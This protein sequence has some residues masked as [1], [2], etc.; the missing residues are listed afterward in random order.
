MIVAV[1][2]VGAK[3]GGAARIA[4]DAVAGLAAHEAV[5]RVVVFASPEELRAFRFASE[6][7]T[8][9]DVIDHP[10]AEAAAGRIMW[11]NNGLG[12]A[13][14][15][16][17]ASVVLSLSSI[18]VVPDVPVVNY[19]QQPLLYDDA[20][21][22]KVSADT[23]ARLMALRPLTWR[24]ARHAAA[25]V[26]QTT[27]MRSVVSEAWNLEPASIVVAT[28][29]PPPWSDL[30]GER[31]ND[32]LW[33]GHPLGYKRWGQAQWIHARFRTF[34]ADSRLLATLEEVSGEGVEA[35][36]HVPAQALRDHY[37]SVGALLV[38]SMSESLGLPL[39]EAMAAG[40]PI[41]APDY[42][43]SR[44]VCDNAALY[45]PPEEPVQAVERLRDARDATVVADLR[46]RMANRVAAIRAEDGWRR[47]A[48][49]VCALG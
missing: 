24:S 39:L 44:A 48:D 47:L 11:S 10:E 28:P 15:E 6:H 27:W 31:S 26:V 21:R 37:D 32:I 12:D 14:A 41:V 49:T 40:C 38:T 20:A 9:V 3:I 18:G 46:T 36:G 29:T 45:Y 25:H 8:R 19:Y 23:Q 16:H 22:S 34:A 4:Q 2:A 42:P 35:L 43:W 30:G 1:D 7:D 17:G 33:V 13:V 5:E